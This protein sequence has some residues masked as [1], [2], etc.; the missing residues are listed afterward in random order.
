MPWQMWV[1]AAI[2]LYVCGGLAYSS[3][4]RCWWR[5]QHDAIKMSVPDRV[6]HRMTVWHC[7]WCGHREPVKW[8]TQT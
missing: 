2:G 8:G 6:E 3:R 5:G 1:L 7:R 4:L